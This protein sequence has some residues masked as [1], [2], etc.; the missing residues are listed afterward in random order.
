[1]WDLIQKMMAA[2]K[3]HSGWQMTSPGGRDTGGFEVWI[4]AD[5]YVVSIARHPGPKTAAE[6][7]ADRLVRSADVIEIGQSHPT[8]T[9][10]AHA[11]ALRAEAARILE[12]GL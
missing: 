5:R 1:M 2:A 9:D 8:V 6:K 4:G 3:G 12:G 7:E 11:R 10:L